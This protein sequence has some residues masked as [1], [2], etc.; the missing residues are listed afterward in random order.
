MNTLTP[1]FTTDNLIIRGLKSSDS[2]ALSDIEND[3]DVQ[4]LAQPSYLAPYS[5]ARWAS[6]LKN[7]AEN[8]NNIL[9]VVLETRDTR[10]VIGHLGLRLDVPKNRDATLGVVIGKNWW[11]KGYGTEAC[12]W[13]VAHEFEEL[14]LHRVSLVVWGDN[15]RARRVYEKM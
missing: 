5:D 3:A 10:E 7:A 9:K 8:P 13:A 2:E 6:V 15:V 4:K 12:K 11:G 1:M 14:G